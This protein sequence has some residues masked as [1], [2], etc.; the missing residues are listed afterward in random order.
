MAEATFER[1]AAALKQC[2]RVIVTSH[3][4]A[5]GD[6]VGSVAALT[7]ALRQL[8]KTVYPILDSQIPSR[9]QFVNDETAITYSRAVDVLPEADA[10]VMVDCAALDRLGDA[11]R[12]LSDMER[13]IAIDHHASNMHFAELSLVDEHASS[14]GEILYRLIGALG[15]RVEGA[16]AAAIYISIATDTGRFSFENTTP[17]CLRYVAEIVAGGLPIAD[18]ARRVF[19]NV[20]ESVLR[21][22][23][24]AL[25]SIETFADGKIATMLLT[26][27]MFERTGA[28]RVDVPDFIDT[29]KE[30]ENIEIAVLFNEVADGEVKLSFRSREIDVDKVAAKY[31]GGGHRRASGAQLKGSVADVKRRVVG[32]LREYL[33]DGTCR[34]ATA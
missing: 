16:I 5:D 6:A 22:E 23:A 8:G 32:D 31:A 14:T 12:F 33:G 21:L 19:G 15:V 30:L 9:F 28:R 25:D 11:R 34:D 29:L 2:R 4:R 17:A 18:L 24:L 13:T 26:N 20:P 7:L 3:V 1:V 27:E 10:F